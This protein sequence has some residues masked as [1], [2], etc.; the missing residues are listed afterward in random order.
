MF[1]GIVSRGADV[2]GA[3][4]VRQQV[5]GTNYE[6]RAGQVSRAFDPGRIVEATSSCPGRTG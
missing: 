4:R 1:P 2:L 6:S 5:S 3:K